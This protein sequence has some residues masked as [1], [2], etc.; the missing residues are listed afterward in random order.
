VLLFS[1]KIDV[2]ARKNISL[3][4]NRLLI[5]IVVEHNI[6]N[7]KIS[8]QEFQDYKSA[9]NWINSFL[10]LRAVTTYVNRFLS[11]EID[12]NSI[13]VAKLARFIPCCNCR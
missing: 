2:A 10:R 8:K 7:M 6:T 5:P 3:K 4:R 12:L 11:S 9:N 13:F 1:Q